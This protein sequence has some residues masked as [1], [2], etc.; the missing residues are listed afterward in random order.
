MG[1]VV[2]ALTSNMLFV[3]KYLET[4]FSL[5]ESL[6]IMKPQWTHANLSDNIIF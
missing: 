4:S 6:V 1:V 3:I 5:M 2:V